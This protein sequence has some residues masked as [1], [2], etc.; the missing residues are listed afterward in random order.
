MTGIVLGVGIAAVVAW[1]LIRT[2]VRIA[3]GFL[4]ATTFLVPGTVLVPG[5]F[6]GYTNVHRLVLALF[7]LNIIRKIARREIPA[8]VLKPTRVSV[9]L[10]LWVVLAFLIGIAM[11]DSSFP[12]GASVFLW[13]FMLE[14]TV[15]F[16]FVLAAAR[17]IGD[18]WWVARLVATVVVLAA[19]VAV[20]EHFS[21][22]SVARS[23][24]KLMRGGGY[25]GVPPLG[26]RGGNV[27]VQSGFEFSLAFGWA[28]TVLLPLVLVVASRARNRLLRLTPAIVVVAIAWTYARS[29]YVGV[30]VA[31]LLLLASSRYDRRIAA[32]VLAGTI[33]A[34]LFAV[35]TKAYERTFRSS[36]VQGSTLVRE[37]RLPL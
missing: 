32:Y 12:V 6:S 27:R 8:S 1:Y 10:G 15:F 19:G 9:V 30:A 34:L 11:A 23:I 35:G 22:R 21:Q 3:L 17:A 24:A 4:L 33:A 2:S 13:V 18:P 36:E 26:R 28:A 37:E 31:G 7:V 20:Y 5:S 29:A 14:Y 16:L 25:L